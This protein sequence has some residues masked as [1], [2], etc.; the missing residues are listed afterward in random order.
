MCKICRSSDCDSINARIEAGET[1]RSIAQ[2]Y[3]T[4]HSTV[5]RHARMCM[6]SG[7]GT[8]Q[9]KKKTIE[10]SVPNEKLVDMPDIDV[11]VS[12][13]SGTF[14]DL[15]KIMVSNIHKA[16]AAAGQNLINQS[17]M[18]SQLAKCTGD[19]ISTM[20]KSYVTIELMNDG[21]ISSSDKRLG[22]LMNYQ[23]D[24]IMEKEVK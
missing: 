16:D 7:K 10:K 13:Y 8:Y 14:Q 15:I 11:N 17:R 1:N 24:K 20:V 5:A 18:Y 12:D 3:D 23:N 19:V 9:Q 6:D 4:S 21:K 2:F 22:R